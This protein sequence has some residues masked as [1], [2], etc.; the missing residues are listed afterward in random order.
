MTDPSHEL[1][2]CAARLIRNLRAVRVRLGQGPG[3]AAEVWHHV[4]K[5]PPSS[6][7][8]VSSWLVVPP[9]GVNSQFVAL[10]AT[11]PVAIA[12]QWR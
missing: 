12:I 3:G 5:S 6:V 4:I 7:S 2:S 1:E 11:D 10:F 8:I 9:T